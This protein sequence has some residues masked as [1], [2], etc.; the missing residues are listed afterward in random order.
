M[1]QYGKKPLSWIFVSRMMAIICFLIVVV[2]AN[3]LTYYVTNPFYNSCVTFLNENFWLLIIIAVILLAGDIFGVFAFPLNLPS[4]IIKAIGSVFFIAF[5]LRVIQWVDSF[6]GTDF[7]NS[8]YLILISFFV[9]PIVFLIVL[10]VGYYFIFRQL[11]HG[12]G[13]QYYGVEE[14]SNAS[15]E[16]T[17]PTL[18][19][20][21]DAKSW[22]DI[23]G[24][25]RE[26]V[27]DIIHRF[28]ADIR[29]KK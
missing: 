11:G 28:R 10:A 15:S 18:R 16:Y 23:G 5:I 19:P 14:I 27:Y 17:D 24:E 25:F 4:P 6:A 3:F 29:R 26:M 7:Y 1:G 20:L 13:A 2:L 8:F 9:V 21:S 22:E 12:P